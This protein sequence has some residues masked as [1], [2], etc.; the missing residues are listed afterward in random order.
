MGN[1]EESKTKY[2]CIFIVLDIPRDELYS[3]INKRV[4]KMFDLGLLE[5]VENLL[6]N[7]IVNQ[8]SQS[9]Q[10]IGCKE[11]FK[12][13]NNELTLNELKELISKNSRNYAKRQLTFMKGFK[14]AKWFN[15]LTEQREIL[16]YIKEELQNYDRN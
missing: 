9:M 8:D 6:Q 13:F 11:F 1:G 2:N 3:R 12:Y 4:T 15:P 14:G 16:N 10:A 5:E 7:K